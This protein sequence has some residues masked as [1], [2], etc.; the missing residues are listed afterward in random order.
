[1]TLLRRDQRHPGAAAPTTGATP[2]RLWTQRARK[3]GRELVTMH[4]FTAEHGFLVL[5]D[6][7]PADGPEGRRVQAGPYVFTTQR[8]ADEFAEEAGAVLTHLGCELT[9]A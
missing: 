6:V 4:C 1:M 3:D 9:L 7:F 5:C 8:E 2:H